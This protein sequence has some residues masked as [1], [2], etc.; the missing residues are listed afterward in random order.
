[1]SSHATNFVDDERFDGLYL[2]VAATTRGIEPLLDS[3]F[4]FLRRKT[5]FFAGPPGR[6]GSDA[7]TDA[8]L[9][10]VQQVAQKH[11]ALWKAQTSAQASNKTASKAK[12]K[13][14]KAASPIDKKTKKKKEDVI[15]MDPSTGGFDISSKSSKS[16][17]SNAPRQPA[18][19]Q[20]PVPNTKTP[21]PPAAAAATKPDSVTETTAAAAPATS[22]AAATPANDKDDKAP[23]PPGN[24]G[25][26]DGKYVWTQSLAEVNMTV[27]VPEHTRGRDLHVKIAKQ[28]LQVGLR[29]ARTASTAADDD[30]MIVNAPLTKAVIVD[31]SF[32]MVEDGNRLVINLQKLHQMEWWDAVCVGDTA[33]DVKKIQ[34]ENSSLNDLDGETRKT[35][36]K[37]RHGHMPPRHG[38]LGP[39]LACYRLILDQLYLTLS[40]CCNI[41]R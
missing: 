14:G 30:W 10:K 36:E 35:V 9:A 25:T 37:V 20:S 26:V 5:D 4:S 23:P 17:S 22:A 34:P 29:S 38:Y 8:A 7:G 15:E 11:A 13:P 21:P 6:A 24:G 27:P 12:A 40:S 2:Q 32:W 16:S 41:P 1:M 28:H 31:D 39:C 19:A 33:I 3:V 18:A